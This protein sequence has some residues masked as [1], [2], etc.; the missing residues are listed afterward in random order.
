MARPRRSGLLLAGFLS[1]AA[2]AGPPSGVGAP[3]GAP[4]PSVSAE[5]V[6]GR[7]PFSERLGCLGCGAV[8]YA[9][10]GTT[11]F[12]FVLMSSL[13]PEQVAGCAYL[14]YRAFAR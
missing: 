13:F 3:A 2:L 1:L 8:I 9:A 6:L 12:G 7:G 5:S 10:S 14:C 11:I 4:S